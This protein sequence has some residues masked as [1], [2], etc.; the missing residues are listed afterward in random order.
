[1]GRT[2][3]I[4]G[5]TG[6]MGRALIPELAQRGHEVI[7]LVRQQSV[8]KLPK[9]CRAVVGDALDSRSFTAFVP[10]GS[11]FVQ[12]VGV[13]HPSPATFHLSQRGPTCADNA[14]CATRASV[15]AATDSRTETRSISRNC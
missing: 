12:L 4:T 13:A 10:H 2:V 1:M 3:F 5:G 9:N 14:Q 8:M 6:Y 15:A 11:S 7:A